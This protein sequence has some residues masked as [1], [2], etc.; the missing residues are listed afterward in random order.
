MRG[1]TGVQSLI[2]HAKRNGGI[3]TRREVL[4]LGYP[5]RTFNRRVNEGVFVRVVPGVFSLPGLA[6]SSD[7]LL[8]AA[9]VHFGAVV[10]HRSA[11]RIHEMSPIR[12]NELEVTVT[13][14]GT[15][16]FPGVT[17]HQTTDLLP[18]HVTLVRGTR[19]TAPART[20]V[21]LASVLSRV[22]LERVLDNA[23]AAA[24]VD[25]GTL[26]ELFAALSR[27]GKPGVRKL[28][29]LLERRVGSP[30]LQTSELEAR[31]S[32][33]LE[34]AGLPE[35]AREF[36]APWLR[37]ISGRIDFAFTDHKVLVECDGRKW[38]AKY[39]AFEIDRRRDNAAQLAGWT[40][41]RFTWRMVVDDPVA[42]VADIRRALE[43][44]Q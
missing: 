11:A 2:T 25:L 22:N 1:M 40:V 32:L 12:G 42:V 36:E 14:R 6:T 7:I 4:A 3:I 15:H 21:D 17:V 34:R 31:M 29:P 28:Q 37:P 24:K 27:K 18:E 33:L 8:R 44:G 20:I 26:V 13:H 38:H 41:L 9:E 39:D 30:I 35:P 10:S 19:L 43:A 16:K 23:L 5:D